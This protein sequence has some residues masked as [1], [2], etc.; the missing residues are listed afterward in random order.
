MTTPTE[1]PLEGIRV[2]ELGQVLAGPFAGAVFADLGAE[3]IKVERP[4]G[5]DDGRRIGAAF[6]YGDSMTFHEFNRNKKS[7]TIDLKS[8]DGLAQLD[9]LIASADI[10]VHNLRP[11]SADELGIGAAR[12]TQRHPRLIYC[13][14]GAFGHQ[15]PM[16]LTP[17][18]E[19]IMQAFAGLSSITGEPDGPPVRMGASVCD[20]GTGMW[21]VIGA[22]SLLERRRRTGRGGIV[23][24]SLFETALMWAGQKICGYANEGKP[25]ERHASGHPGMTPYEAFDAADGPFLICAGNDRLF[26]KLAEVLGHPEWPADARFATNRERLKHKPDLLPMITAVLKGA[27]RRHW[28]ARLA[29]AGVPCAPINSIAELMDEPQTRAVGLLQTPPGED[30]ILP[31]LPISFDG[32]RPPLRSAAPRLGADNGALL[33]REAVADD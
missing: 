14:M 13:E 19:P 26:G 23:N 27:P 33:K 5:G 30:F 32:V 12:L 17:G 8:P 6:R 11:G 21:T 2:I 29:E 22:L 18:Y 16:R 20:M 15:G 25:P 24:T 28:L 31:G 7:V 3:V 9:A 10:L 4:D 1:L